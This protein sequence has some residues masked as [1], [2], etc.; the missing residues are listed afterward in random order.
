MGF[1]VPCRASAQAG[2]PCPHV[3]L[4]HGRGMVFSVLGHAGPGWPAQ[5]FISN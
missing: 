2:K 3:D 4:V 1:A 5:I